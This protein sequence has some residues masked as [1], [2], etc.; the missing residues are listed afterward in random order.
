[1]FSYS[2]VVIARYLT[3]VSYF[4]AVRENFL[5]SLLRILIF[6]SAW[7]HCKETFWLHGWMQDW[8]CCKR[9]LIPGVGCYIIFVVS[10]NHV[11]FVMM[12]IADPRRIFHQWWLNFILWSNGWDHVVFVIQWW[13]FSSRDLWQWLCWSRSLY[14]L[15]RP[16]Q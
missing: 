16:F 12:K 7:G 3:R 5:M 14:F 13:F 4:T 8:C 15:M 2:F 1:M 9:T 6:K 11:L 10:L